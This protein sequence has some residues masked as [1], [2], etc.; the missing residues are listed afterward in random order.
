MGPDGERVQAIEDF[1]PLRE[2]L[3][4]QQFLGCTNWLRN[5]LV[6]EYAQAAKIL[7]EWQKPGAV[8]PACGLGPGNTEGCKA[9]RAIKL[10]AGS[11][12]C[13]SGAD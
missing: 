9:V 12:P 5:Y 1:A 13:V 6:A 4:I 7:G 2:K 11:T 8:Y 3:H 10:M